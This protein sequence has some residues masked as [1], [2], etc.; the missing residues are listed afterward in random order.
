M[1][2]M[3]LALISFGAGAFALLL[4]AVAGPF[5]RVGLPLAAALTLMRWAAYAG[6]GAGALC[7]VGA[8]LAYRKG[9][10]AA[11]AL[12]LLGLSM[13]IAATAIPYSWLRASTSHPQIHD[14][15]TDLENPPAFVAVLPLREE[16]ANSVEPNRDTAEQQRRG[17]PDIMPLTLPQ[18][19][20]AV[21]DRALQVVQ[22]MGWQI[23]AA[24]RGA[25]RLEAIATTRWFGFKDDIVLR[26]TPWGAGTRAD[27]RSVSRIGI[28]DAGTNAARIEQFLAR[29]QER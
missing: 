6:V 9:R 29:L 2:P 26:L 14:I 25:G 24:D 8:G 21:F 19:P 27:M 5:Y 3:R 12:A 16:A 11:A 18:P 15:S 4:L 17:Y 7:L 1:R 28:G 23:V 22:E 10:P 20:G 13:A